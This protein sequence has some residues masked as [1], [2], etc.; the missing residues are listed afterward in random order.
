MTS[1][2][3]KNNHNSK[4]TIEQIKKRRDKFTI[5]PFRKLHYQKA[6]VLAKIIEKQLKLKL[7]TCLT[8]SRIALLYFPEHIRL[9]KLNRDLFER[10]MNSTDFLK[11]SFKKEAKVPTRWRIGIPASLLVNL[12]PKHSWNVAL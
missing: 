12:E 5:E 9:G 4:P 3:T 7:N 8:W 1:F 11:H 2:L 6:Q 10:H